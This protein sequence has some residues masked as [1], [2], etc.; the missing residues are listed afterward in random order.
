MHVLNIYRETQYTIDLVSASRAGPGLIKL[1]ITILGESHVVL[2]N[3]MN[4]NKRHRKRPKSHITEAKMVVIGGFSVQIN[5]QSC[6]R[7]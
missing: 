3:Y 1:F 6:F 4:V 5:L 7:R 2:Q